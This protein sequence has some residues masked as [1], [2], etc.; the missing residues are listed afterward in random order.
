MTTRTKLN[1]QPDHAIL[2]KSDTSLPPETHRNQPRP[3]FS[4][5]TC[6]L[7]GVDPQSY[8]ADL[9]T[10]LVNGWPQARIDEL[11]PW[12]WAEPSAP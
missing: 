12:Y 5:A 3:P 7:N 6:K 4:R 10:R 8:L 11:M 9:L 2:A 1:S